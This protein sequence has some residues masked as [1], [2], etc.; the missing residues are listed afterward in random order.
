ME[1][2]RPD[3]PAPPWVHACTTTRLGGISTGVYAALNLGDHVGDEPHRVARNRTL[4]RTTLDLPSEP[5][6]LTQVHGCEV[7]EIGPA[8]P[9][10]HTADAAI[11]RRPGAVCAVMTADCLPL[12]VCN[13]R[14]H[15]V[16]AVHA[17]WRGLAAGVIES[18][19]AA[20]DEAPADLLAWLGPAIGP[21]AFEVGPE[22]REALLAAD[23]AVASAFQ[24]GTDDRWLADLFALA[25]ARL[26]RAGVTQIFGGGDCTWSAPDRFFS[27]RR[28]GV[29]GRMASLIWMSAQE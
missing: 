26:M 22:V 13:R 11:A 1:L 8:A 18:T 20:L 24:P 21:T 23:P 12:L 16:A 15:S 19:L 2:I 27:F 5:V 17:G 7:I 10:G 28:D 6:W 4:V 14:G 29:T 3:W 9:P 25:R